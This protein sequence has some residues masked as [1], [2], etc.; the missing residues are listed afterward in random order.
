MAAVAATAVPEEMEI[1]MAAAG[2]Q[3]SMVLPQWA[4]QVTDKAD[5]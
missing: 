4:G 5:K 1:R 3:G 2:L